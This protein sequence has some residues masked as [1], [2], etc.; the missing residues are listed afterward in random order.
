MYL[1]VTGSDLFKTPD[2]PSSPAATGEL[3]VI[4]YDVDHVY[5]HSDLNVDLI[6]VVNIIFKSY[7]A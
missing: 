4:L 3:S 5:L 2:M 1:Y 6:Q 7:I